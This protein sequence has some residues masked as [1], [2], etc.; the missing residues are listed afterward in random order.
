MRARAHTRTP[1]HIYAH[2]QAHTLTHAH[3]TLGTVTPLHHDPY[4]NAFAQ[5][6]GSKTVRLFD[7]ETAPERLYISTDP[8][9]RNTSF[10]NV[11]DPDYEKHPLFRGTDCAT[12]ELNEGDLLYIPRK[13]WHHVRATS[14]SMSVSFW[15]L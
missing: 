5:V 14:L 2:T 6:V 15:W 11:E 4:H 12:V 10:V 7:P 1:A 9:Q 8:L 3:T 13:W